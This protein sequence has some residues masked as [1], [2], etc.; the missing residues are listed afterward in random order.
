MICSLMIGFDEL[1]AIIKYIFIKFISQDHIIR[2]SKIFPQ[3]GLMAVQIKV[4]PNLSFG[5]FHVLSLF[6]YQSI[7]YMKF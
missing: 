2:I 1:R 7:I 4:Y 3:V 5:K 6:H